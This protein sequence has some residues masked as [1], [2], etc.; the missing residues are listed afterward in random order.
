M[1]LSLQERERV[2]RSYPATP[3]LEDDAAIAQLVKSAKEKGRGAGDDPYS[4]MK[5]GSLTTA[6][7]TD[8]KKEEQKTEK[9]SEAKKDAP[10]SKKGFLGLF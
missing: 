2:L 4:A 9:P 10:R 6:R 7:V 1:P 3:S 5:P 8:E